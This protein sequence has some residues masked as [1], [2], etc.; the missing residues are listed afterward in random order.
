MGSRACLAAVLALT[1]GCSAIAAAARPDHDLSVLLAGAPRGDV[2]R[3]LGRPEWTAATGAGTEAAYVVMVGQE[4][5]WGDH[6]ARVA[7]VGLDG[8]DHVRLMPH[9]PWATTKSVL[10]A[11]LAVP[12]MIAADVVGGAKEVAS[13]R[14]RRRRVLVRYD[15]DD[16]VTSFYM[17]GR[18]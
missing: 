17:S 11:L 18:G 4:R 15:L 3:E 8:V 1:T 9:R 14:R 12:K 2:E 16:R 13:W 7:R 10:R 6:V 5:D